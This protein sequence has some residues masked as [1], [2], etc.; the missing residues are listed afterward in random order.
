M[1]VSASGE[2]AGVRVVYSGK[3]WSEQENEMIKNRHISCICIFGKNGI[4][5]KLELKFKFKFKFVNLN[6]LS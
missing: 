2:V 5:Y 4:V 6:G 3:R 1:T